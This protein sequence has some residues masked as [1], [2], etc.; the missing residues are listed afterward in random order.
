MEN[1]IFF[2][3]YL[4]IMNESSS[5]IKADSND[6]T[7]LNHQS[8]SQ[9]AP[10]LVNLKQNGTEAATINNHEE[11]VMLELGIDSN[12]ISDPTVRLNTQR[13]KEATITWQNINVRYH[14]QKGLF[15]QTV[16]V[17]RCNKKQE[18]IKQIIKNGQ[19]MF[20]T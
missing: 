14:A 17:F 4:D 1:F 3:L 19:F 10:T 9:A 15:A 13:S 12:D 20:R 11:D 7:K 6:Q 5:E 16:N 2:G 18:N 8:I